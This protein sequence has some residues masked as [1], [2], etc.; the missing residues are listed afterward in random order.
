MPPHP[1][2]N[3]LLAEIDALLNWWVHGPWWQAFVLFV[4][5]VLVFAVFFKALASVDDPGVRAIVRE[6]M[7]GR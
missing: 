6:M 4:A 2:L 3:A 1:Q 7:R 5:I